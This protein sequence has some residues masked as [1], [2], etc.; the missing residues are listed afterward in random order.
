MLLKTFKLN[1]PYFILLFPL[2]A[3]GLW[4]KSLMFPVGFEFFQAEN[5][6]PLYQPIQFLISSSPLA[7]NLAALSLTIL[8]SFL[9]LKLNVQYSFIKVRTF[10]PSS[11]FILITSGM[12]DFHAM[13]PVYPAALFLIL[14]IDRMFDTHDK[15]SIHS[16]AFDS[17]IF[18]AIGSLFY[19]HLVFF[20]PFLWIGF[21][22]LKP[23]VNWREYILTTLGFLLPW[24]AVIAFYAGTNRTDEFIQ[25]LQSNITFHQDFLRHNLPNQIYIGYLILLTAIGS[26]FLIGQYDGKKISSRR[27][28]KAFFWIFLISITMIVA[29]QSVSQEIVMILA[30]PLTYLISNYL[31]FMK[32]QIWGEVFLYI[33]TAGVIYLQFV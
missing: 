6:M 8:L 28:F 16:N 15:E 7:S 24:L 5:A 14:T 32:R 2:V 21:I 4:I 3:V 19:L 11:L 18:L 12:N 25:T 27:Y 22:I 30:I 17:G 9:I 20:F 26:I 33:L 1:Q 29:D 13:H 23:N 31:I 10:L